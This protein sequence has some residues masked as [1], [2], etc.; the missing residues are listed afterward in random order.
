MKLQSFIPGCPILSD[1]ITPAYAEDSSEGW[2]ERRRRKILEAAAHHFSTQNYHTV[3]MDQVA[4]SADMG[5]ATLYRYFASKED[6]F[7]AVFDDA[8]SNLTN[9]L[10]E[11]IQKGGSS[12]QLLHRVIH[13]LVPELWS[14]LRGLKSFDGGEVQLAERKRRMFRERRRT[15]TQQIENVLKAGQDRG[16]I[17]NLDC[18][19]TA[20]LIIG[21]TWASA[22]SSPADQSAPLADLI[23]DVFLNG[24]LQ[25][26]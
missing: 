10:E 1:L 24:T 21:M 25:K 9:L 22:V 2:R 19:M 11:E 18:R 3:T 6:L 26:A 16:E 12:A 14:H 4:A 8:L 7:V 17:R 20:E 15:L 23:T 5:K 13:L